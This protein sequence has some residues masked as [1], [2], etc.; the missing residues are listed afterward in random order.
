MLTLFIFIYSKKFLATKKKAEKLEQQLLQSQKMEA[1]GTLVGG[2]AHDFNNMLAAIV[3]NTYLAKSRIQSDQKLLDNIE[4]INKTSMRAADMIKQLL[5]FARKDRVEMQTFSLTHF[6]EEAVTLASTAV[7]E[8]IARSCEVSSEDLYVYA[9]STQLQQVMMNLINNSKDALEG[10]KD[11]KIICVLKPYTA[12]ADFRKLHPN[13][14]GKRF[15]C[16]TI[17]DNGNGIPEE[18]ASKVFDPFFTTKG[19]GKGTGLG[20]AMV[21]GVV[22]GHSGAIKVDSLLGEGTT[23]TIYLPLVNPMTKDEQVPP[24]PIVT[25][26][27]ELIL[28]ADDE[29]LVRDMH[30]GILPALGYRVISARNGEEAV[31]LFEQNITEISLVILDVVMPVMGGIDAAKKIKRLNGGIPIVFATGYDRGNLPD[32]KKEVVGHKI[33]N[34]PFSVE[35]LSQLIIQ[36]LDGRE[37]S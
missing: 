33:I 31:R 25:G 22:E 29:N 30:E 13:C 27:N 36:T 20:L 10:V 8:S 18:I 17:R 23:F 16:L 26:Q 1:I 4:A 7:P 35:S 9:D 32:E 2:I 28:I 3:G 5:T 24:Q 14:K 37:A 21:Y 19:V 11:G 15:A 6:L 34:K 12:D